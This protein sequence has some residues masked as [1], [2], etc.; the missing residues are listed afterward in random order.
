MRNNNETKLINN[1]KFYVLN[2]TKVAQKCSTIWT[3]GSAKNVRLADGWP[4]VVA[5]VSF[6]KSH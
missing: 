6:D 2:L 3:E 5:A 1:F 4:S